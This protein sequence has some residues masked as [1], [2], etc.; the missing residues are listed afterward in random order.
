M[1]PIVETT[2][3][4]HSFKDKKEHTEEVL[5]VFTLLLYLLTLDDANVLCILR[6]LEDRKKLCSYLIL[7]FHVTTVLA[8][9]RRTHF[10]LLL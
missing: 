7:S 4:K 6:H 9:E 3:G 5:K 1:L 10:C 8:L 2:A